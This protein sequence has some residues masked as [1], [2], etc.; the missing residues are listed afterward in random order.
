MENSP[1]VGHSGER[2]ATYISSPGAG[3]LGKRASIIT[4]PPA[5]TWLR[6]SPSVQ[7]MGAFQMFP[8]CRV[9]PVI[10]SHPLTTTFS[11]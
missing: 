6:P 10:G 8:L 4:W 2:S 1:K 9:Q 5:N 11:P 3:R 7:G